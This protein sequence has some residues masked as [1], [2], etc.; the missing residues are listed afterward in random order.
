MV[1]EYAYTENVVPHMYKYY[2]FYLHSKGKWKSY[3]I[4]VW[5]GSLTSTLTF[6]LVYYFT[7]GCFM[8][9]E[10]KFAPSEIDRIRYY[11]LTLLS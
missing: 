5:Q 1:R 3:F 6:K 2:F 4:S 9:S 10:N 7:T 11:P 8:Y